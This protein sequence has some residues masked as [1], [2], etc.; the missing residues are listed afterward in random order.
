MILQ[1]SKFAH[2]FISKPCS[3]DK[4]VNTIK[5]NI[6]METYLGNDSLR[7]IINGIDDLPGQPE[8]LIRLESEF[9]DRNVSLQKISRIISEDFV[10]SAKILQLVN[11]AFF[12]VENEIVNLDNAISLLGVNTI[13]SLIIFLKLSEYIT[14][15]N[16]LSFNFKDLIEHSVKVARGAQAILV[17]ETGDK[18]KGKE[19]Y[20][21]GLLH[22]IGK[23]IL[24]KYPK[25]MEECFKNG[26]SSYS[27]EYDKLGTSH[28]EVG[29]YLL[30]LWNLPERIIN[31]VAMHHNDL[32]LSVIDLN[33]AV[34]IAD[35]VNQD[36]DAEGV[37]EITQYERWSNIIQNDL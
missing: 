27:D 16:I 7:S 26:T 19:A 35:I 15:Q 20:T 10:L 33:S 13:K 31:A 28:A 12:G 2:Q 5:K 36:E 29:A 3:S 32:D 21:A 14:N 23:L 4:L 6:R 34:K 11:S 9:K 22:D 24:L 37:F 18:I 1:T 8:L 17:S 25:Y 30:R